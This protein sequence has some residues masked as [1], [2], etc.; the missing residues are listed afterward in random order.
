[1]INRLAIKPVELLEALYR[2]CYA[3]LMDLKDKIYGLLGLI[4]NSD[5]FIPKPNYS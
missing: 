4:Y 5:V 2:S 3:L 1:R